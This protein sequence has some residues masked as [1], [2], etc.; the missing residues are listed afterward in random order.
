MDARSPDPADQRNL[1]SHREKSTTQRRRWPNHEALQQFYRAIELDPDYASPH[2]MAARC[3]VQR[4]A[5]GWTIDRERGVPETARLA[6]RAVTLGKEDATALS[7]GGFALAYVI[8]ELDDGAAFVDR[9][10]TL[11]PN[12]AVAWHGGLVRIWLGDPEAARP[13]FGHAMRLSP[14]D[15]IIGAMRTGVAY[16]ATIC[17]LST[18]NPVCVLRVSSLQNVKQMSNGQFSDV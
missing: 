10:L 8:H 4:I 12:L 11:N 9:A 7:N 3:Y 5:N 18:L 13:R 6:R 17:A 16:V 1:V 15:P 14:F 2:G